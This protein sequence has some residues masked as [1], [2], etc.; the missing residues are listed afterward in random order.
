MALDATVRGD[1]HTALDGSSPDGSIVRSC[2]SLILPRFS[3]LAR[4]FAVPGFHHD[5][6]GA[7]AAAARDGRDFAAHV[8]T[9]DLHEPSVT[10]MPGS[11]TLDFSFFERGERRIATPACSHGENRDARG[12]ARRARP[13]MC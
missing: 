5:R 13:R 2:A 11:H 8:G 1:G 7:A 9:A 12:I 6:A 3:A 4:S 10:A